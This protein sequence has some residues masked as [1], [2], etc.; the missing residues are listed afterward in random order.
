MLGT[1]PIT[2]VTAIVSPTALASPSIAAAK[3]PDL[4]YGNTALEMTSHF[5]AP[6]DNIASLEIADTV[7]IIIIAKITPAVKKSSPKGVPEKKG[8]NPRYLFRGI[9]T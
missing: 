6:R 2:I 7:G 3:I 1:F 4:A 9:S 5:V 8:I